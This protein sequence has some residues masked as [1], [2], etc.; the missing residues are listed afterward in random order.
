MARN[1]KIILFDG[2]MELDPKEIDLLMIL[3]LY[4][5]NAL[6]LRYKK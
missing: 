3:D 4:K 2:D 1:D 6:G 5:R